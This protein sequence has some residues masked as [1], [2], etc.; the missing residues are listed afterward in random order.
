MMSISIENT[1]FELVLVCR[2]SNMHCEGCCDAR[3]DSMKG[4]KMSGELS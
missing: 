1:L 4:R 2:A 3:W